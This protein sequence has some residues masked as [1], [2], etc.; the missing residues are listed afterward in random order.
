M[1]PVPKTIEQLLDEARRGLDRVS[2]QRARAEMAWGAQLIDIRSELDR[3]R[4]GVIPGAKFIA[5]NVLEWRCDPRSQWRDRE[6]TD[7]PARVILICDEGYQSS[8][9]AATLQQFGLADATDVIGGFQAW[10]AAELPVVPYVGAPGPEAAQRAAQ[11]RL[12]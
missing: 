3:E 7:D 1:H 12:S 6:V 5:R 2:P 10:R 9:A 11:T 4:D 8:L